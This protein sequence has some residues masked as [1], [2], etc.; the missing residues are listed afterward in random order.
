MNI[1]EIKWRLE[2]EPLTAPACKVLQVLAYFDVFDYPLTAEDIFRHSDHSSFIETQRVLH[3]LVERKIVNTQNNL[4]FLF[5]K[6]SNVAY[7]E[8]LQQRAESYYHKAEKY[9]RLISRFPYVRGVFITGSLA[10]ECMSID[11]DIDYLIITEPGRLWLCRTFLTLFK[12][13][14][15]FN[16]RKYFCVNYYLDTNALH[17]PDRNIF[18]ATEIASARAAYNSTVCKQFFEENKW[19][20]E[21][22]P[23]HQPTS[24]FPVY[25]K[26]K[27]WWCEFSEWA[28]SGA[29]GDTIDNYMM[30]IF[31]RR[32]K[33]RY[34]GNDHSRFE[35][36]FRSRRNVS[37]HHPHGFQFK[38]L[39]AYERN[40]ALLEATLSIRLS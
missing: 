38:V 4:Y 20:S 39:Q 3:D 26:K 19:Y 24:L 28:L 16:S 13:T 22:Y 5:G 2:Q 29:L 8:E 15:L 25:E 33:T 35:V 34:R 9:A 30:R 14:V 32:W 21:F 36:N 18:T 40:I 10:K 17:I 27:S 12:K 7:R 11:G 23:R 1:P 37:K 6:F 31:V